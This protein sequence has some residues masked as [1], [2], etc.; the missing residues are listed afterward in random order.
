MQLIFSATTIGITEWRTKYRRDMNEKDNVTKA[1]AV[2][3]LLNFET[4]WKRIRNFYFTWLQQ[5]QTSLKR[6]KNGKA[7]GLN[8]EK[9]YQKFRQ[10]STPL[11]KQQNRIL[12]FYVLLL[13][14]YFSQFHSTSS[15]NHFKHYLSF[16]KIFWISHLSN[17]FLG[18]FFIHSFYLSGQIL[19]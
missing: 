10:K 7:E 5:A 8:L 3:S 13:S 6:F 1:V 9:I 19:Q 2:D 4:V 15:W 11:A 18:F 12:V 17:K 14:W 16:D